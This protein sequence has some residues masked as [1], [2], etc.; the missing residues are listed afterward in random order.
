[1]ARIQGLVEEECG[2]YNPLMQLTKAYHTGTQEQVS[3]FSLVN[4]KFFGSE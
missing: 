4:G 2:G 1:M 3:F